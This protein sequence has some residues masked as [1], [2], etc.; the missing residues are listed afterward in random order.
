MRGLKIWDYITNYFP[1]RL[2]LQEQLDPSKTYLFAYNPHGVWAWGLWANMLN[3]SNK[4]LELLEGIKLRILTLD[5]NFLLPFYRDVIMGLGFASVSRE[6]CNYLLS[7]GIS[8][9][10]VIGGAE[11]TIDAKPGTNKLKI[12]NKKGFIRMALKHGANLVPVFTFGENELF[13]Q[14]PNPPGS[15]IR[16]LQT[17]MKHKYGFVATPFWGRGHLPAFPRRHEIVTIIGSPI[18]VQKKETFNEEDVEELHEKYI[19]A[20]VN[21]Y[22]VYADKYA[23]GVKLEI[24]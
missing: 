12:K 15:R 9:V 17:W 4:I 14:I 13:D 1:A 20:L 5:M 18:E 23:K 11:D 24:E 22:S 10:I 16:R 2:I 3:D 6:S 21:L 19:D 8:I 7:K